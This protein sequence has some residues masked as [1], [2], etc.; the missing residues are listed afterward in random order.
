MTRVA[1]VLGAGHGIGRATAARLNAGGCTTV[2][3]SRTRS[4]LEKTASGFTGDRPV[5]LVPGDITD[6]AFRRRLVQQVERR[7]GRIDVLVN[8][9]P[10]PAPG[11]FDEIGTADIGRA[12]D[13]KLVPY[14]DLIKAVAPVMTRH[15]FG[16]IV[17]VVGN[18]GKE[19]EPAMFL[20]GLVNAALANAAKYL[21]GQYAP[22]HITVNCVHPGTIRTPR[23]D[24]AADHL[25]RTGGISREE[26]ESRLKDGISMGRPGEAD[27]VAAVIAFLA[28]AES[29]YLT[30]QQISVDGGQLTC[31]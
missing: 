5:D 6:P 2:L 23:F 21:A 18:I 15:G 11:A 9:G 12:M 30:G 4:D 17:N 25:S 31:V 26:A 19:P 28:S 16:R 1:V 27:E 22:H 14:L 3:N 13:Q 24:R 8:N 10:G 7:H 29:S 20:S